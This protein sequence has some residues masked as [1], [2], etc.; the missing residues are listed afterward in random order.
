[1]GYSIGALV[2]ARRGNDHRRPPSINLLLP[3]V[4]NR[5]HPGRYGAEALRNRLREMREEGEHE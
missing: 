2:V 5:T 1:M 3:A 4:L